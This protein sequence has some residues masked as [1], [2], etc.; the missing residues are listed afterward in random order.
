[1]MKE[2]SKGR[3]KANEETTDDET[4]DDEKV[5]DDEEVH[6]DEEMHDDDEIAD[7]EKANEE[8]ADVEK[9]DAEKTEEGKVN[10]EQTGD[11]QADKD[12]QA[13]DDHATN[14]QAGALISVT[15]KENPKLPPSS[16]SF[17]LSSDYG[18]Q[19]LNISYDVSLAGIVKEPEDTKI[20]SM[21]DVHLQRDIPPFLQAL[22]L[23][24][25]IS[26]IPKQT[27]LTP[28]TTQPT[29]EVQATTSLKN[30]YKPTTVPKVLKKE[31]ANVFQSSSSQEESEYDLKVKLYNKMQQNRSF[32]THDKN[33][34][35]C[36]A[37]INSM[38]LDGAIAKGDLD[39]AKVL[40]QKRGNDVDQD[41]P[42]DTD[43]EK[44]R[45]RRK[46]VEPS[47]K[48]STSKESSKG[49]TPPKASKTNK[50]VNIE[51]VVEEH[52]IEV[53]MDVE[54][55]MLD[56]V[57]KDPNVDDGLEQTWFNDLV[58]AEK[59]PLTFDDLMANP[60]DFTKFSMKRLKKDK[61]TKSDLVG[62][63]Y[64]LLKGTCRRNLD[65]KST[66]KILSVVRVTVDKQFGYGYLKDIVVRRADQ[67]EY[68][69][70]EGDFPRLHLND[71]EDML[72]L[73]VQNKLFNLEGDAIVDIVISLRMFT[74]SI[75]IKRRVEDVQLGVESYQ[76][77]L[78]IT[79]PQAQC[80]GISFKDPYTT[81]YKP[82]RVVYM[83]N[84]K[85]KRLMRADELYKFSDG[86][87]NS[88]RYNKDMPKRKWTEKDKTQTHTMMKKIDNQLLERRI[89]RS[90][91]G[92]VGGRKI[93]TDYRL[94]LRT[95]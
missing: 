69:F 45:S 68:T 66:L 51:E 75:V 58:N 38:S 83:N 35:L 24:V 28:S 7:E 36:N 85:L 79:K 15:Q 77:K 62:P 39:L 48:S 55:P 88:V 23:D 76:K 89:M 34:Y 84:C 19:F 18:N 44:E 5:P 40:K 8:I 93:E 12:D 74:R 81:Q 31:P 30:L 56:D 41:P 64:K 78:N 37:L 22:L 11:D 21:V 33:N 43:K 50:S 47:K 1:M 6:E 10:E 52:V 20:N 87:L 27:T 70:M 9:I 73:H 13:K 4:I 94:L 2:P 90:L 67:K 46:D 95:G 54:E 49:K 17:S 91:E 42:T 86:T 63:T 14:N 26:V 53:A 3:G 57:N 61:I 82:K 60:I 71:I 32:L 59:P 25:L 72:L 92:L 29:T 16:S 80:D 65:M